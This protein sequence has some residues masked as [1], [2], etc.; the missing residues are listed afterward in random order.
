LLNSR[1]DLVTATCSPSRVAGIFSQLPLQ[2]CRHPFYRR[3]GANL[4]NSLG[5]VLPV[6]R[7]LLSDPTCAGSRYGL[8]G[9]F[10][11][12]FSRAPGIGRTAHKGSSSRLYPLLLITRLQGLMRLSY[13]DL[14]RSVSR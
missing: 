6:R 10:L 12:A 9:S 3:Y 11:P 1:L 5:R 13:L 4:P 8:G 14:P 7:R 2:D